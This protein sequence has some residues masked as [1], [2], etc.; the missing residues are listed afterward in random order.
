[1]PLSPRTTKRPPL[2]LQESSTERLDS[3]KKKKRVSQNLPL[4]LMEV[5]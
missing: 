4:A 1:M 3:L 2:T 5:A